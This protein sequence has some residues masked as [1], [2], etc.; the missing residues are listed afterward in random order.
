M[1][2]T[3]EPDTLEDLDSAADR[4]VRDCHD[5]DDAQKSRLRAEFV[6]QALPFAGRMARRYR[7]R[8]ELSD[9]L[10]QVARLGLVKAV[11]RYDPQR[12]S[13]TAYAVIT[14]TGEIKRHFRDHTWGVH[15]PRRMQDLGLEINHA[16]TV[17][18][19]RLAR[20]PTAEEI[21]EHIGSGAAEIRTAQ[22]SAAGYS[23]ASLNAPA[24]DR[25]EAEVGDLLGMP[26]P[27]LGM[28]E[29]RT[30]VEQLLYRL[31]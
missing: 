3:H 24:G 13:F 12:G 30:T 10:V 11:D 2:A 21:A 22:T 17:L 28:V 8:G 19:T 20:T 29:D 1:P 26:D 7:S 5:A 31:P 16:T 18:T 6:R 27:E 14:I 23:L 25:G 15:V 4:Y 9:D